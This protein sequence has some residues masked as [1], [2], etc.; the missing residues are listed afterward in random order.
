MWVFYVLALIPTIVGSV[1]YIKDR[2][3]VWWEW[4]L[5]SAIAFILAGIFQFCAIKGMTADTETWSGHI[6][7]VTHH[8]YWQSHYTTTEDIKDSKGNVIGH[9]TVDH[10]DDHPEFWDADS[11]ID[12]TENISE[13]DF[14]HI[15]YKFG[16]SLTTEK[17][18]KSDF[19][20]G[21]KNVYVY[22]Q[23]NNWIEPIHITK[24]FENRLKAS[25]TLFS[26]SKVPTN[27]TVYEYPENGN[28]RSSNRLF[29]T[30]ANT[31]DLLSFDQ[32]NARLGPRKKINVI[33]IGFGAKDTSIAEWQRSKWLGGKK[34]DLVICFGGG[35]ASNPEWCK[36]FGWSDSELCKKNIESL[37]L[38]DKVDTSILTK[39]EQEIISGYTIKNW[40]SF[41][42]ISISPP[43]WS[44]FVFFL[45][46]A[47][48][49]VGFWVWANSNQYNKFI[50]T[51]FYR[52]R[53]SY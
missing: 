44:Y 43:T 5:S 15:G 50:S 45:V 8:P 23:G 1:L 48:V 52:S 18:Y 17:P 3:V 32:F 46:M 9:R 2:N 42:Y 30:A 20:K 37:F 47:G 13:N 14:V 26:F 34:N 25:P 36:V 24:S 12:H 21:D 35:T 41:D 4:L 6:T 19:Y 51:G 7:Q 16:T 53:Y 27:I 22:Y 39:L 29:G 10:Y 49:E 11:N 31:I 33:I 28:W 38:S 40:H